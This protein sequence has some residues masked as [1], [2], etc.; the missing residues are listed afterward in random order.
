MRKN[1]IDGM[2]L[3]Q[4]VVYGMLTNR[5]VR[6]VLNG[7]IICMETMLYQFGEVYVHGDVSSNGMLNAKRH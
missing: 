5:L 7:M 3:V 1:D 4:Y 2:I 6:D